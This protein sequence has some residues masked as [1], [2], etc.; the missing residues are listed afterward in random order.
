[1]HARGHRVSRQRD[2]ARRRARGTAMTPRLLVLIVALS[3][4]SHALAQS[5]SRLE[6]CLTDV[7]AA[8]RTRGA[9]PA[10]Q[11]WS[12]FLLEGENASFAVNLSEAGC[13]A[14]VAVGE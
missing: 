9:R 7:L 5:P 2:G 11:A 12:G 3:W 8:A 10:G 14:L 4:S 1:A 6:G 13:V